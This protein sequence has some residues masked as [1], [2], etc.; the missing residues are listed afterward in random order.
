VINFA[1]PPAK[2]YI[3]RHLAVEAIVDNQLVR[4]LDSKGLH[5][6]FLTVEEGAYFSVVEVG[7]SRWHSFIYNS[8]LNQTKSK[9]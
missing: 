5:R 3:N 4:H 6:M 1:L 8:P 9:Q 7:N 2:T